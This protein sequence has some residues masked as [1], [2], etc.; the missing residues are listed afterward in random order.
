MHSLTTSLLSLS[1]LST[2]LHAATTARVWTH[3]Y[4]N[5]PGEPFSDMTNYE[6]YKESAPSKDVKTGICANIGVPSYEHSLVSAI[7]VDAELLSHGHAQNFPDS[8]SHCNITVHEV[9]GCIDPP[10]ITK[11]IRKGVEVSK[12]A[13][14]QF[15]AY[16]QV[17][18]Q[19]ECEHPDSHDDH[20]KNDRTADNDSKDGAVNVVTTD[21][22]ASIQQSSNA[23]TPGSNTGSWSMAQQANSERRP[24]QEGRVNNAGHVASSQVVHD[25]LEM[26]KHKNSTN[27]V[28]GKHHANGSSHHLNGTA[29]ANNRTMSRRNLSVRR[30]RVARLY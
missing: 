7:S 12:C 21:K 30:N 11:E 6:N 25:L 3:F 18:V 5:C 17:W 13:T 10:L 28:S 2:P 9:P 19:L 14:R 15:A 4:P 16:S 26:L 29:L 8:D 24:E 20:D 1:L 22:T 23:Q 27:I